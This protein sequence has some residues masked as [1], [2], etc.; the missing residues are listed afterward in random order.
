MAIIKKPDLVLAHFLRN[1]VTELTRT[2]FSNRQTADSQSF[3]GTGS[4]DTFTLTNAPMC[5]NSVTVDSVLQS[6][7]LHYNIDLRSKQVV[8]TSGNLPGAG[9]NNVVLSYDKG[10]NWVYDDKP[11]D[12]L[13]RTSYPRIAVQQISESS[14]PRGASEDDTYDGVTFQIDVLAYKDLMCTDASSNI[15]EGAEV[16]YY[17]ARDVKKMIKEN[18]RTDLRYF[19]FDPR[20]LNFFSVP[21]DE[22]KGI[23]RHIIE[24]SFDAFDIGE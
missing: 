22:D 21:Y 13:S 17:L 24:V 11:R 9:T 10:S 16:S 3:N 15:Y 18:W 2:G 23:Y 4:Q 8:F 12:S 5:I 7:Y 6:P 14:T 1:R 19:M 20:F